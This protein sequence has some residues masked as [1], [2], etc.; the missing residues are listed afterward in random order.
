LDHSVF[1][2]IYIVCRPQGYLYEK[3]AIYENL[4]H[5]KAE[6]ARKLQAFSDQKLKQDVSNPIFFFS[7]LVIHFISFGWG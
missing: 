4:L 1:I 6:I 3:E 5:Q 2:Y 7:S